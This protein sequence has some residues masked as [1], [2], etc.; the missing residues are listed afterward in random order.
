VRVEGGEVVKGGAFEGIGVLIGL[1][2]CCSTRRARQ[3]GCHWGHCSPA[4]FERALVVR[5]STQWCSGTTTVCLV[6]V[7]PKRAVPI[8]LATPKVADDA[9]RPISRPQLHPSPSSRSR[10]C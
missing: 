3:R 2:R 8:E 10:E 7:G 6:L 9:L 5:S 1:G 4:R